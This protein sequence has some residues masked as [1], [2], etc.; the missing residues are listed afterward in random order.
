MEMT[1]VN[2]SEIK[3]VQY[4]TSHAKVPLIVLS[5]KVLRCIKES[6]ARCIMDTHVPSM[7][8]ECDGWIHRAV[9][10]SD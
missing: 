5:Q 1:L 3:S 2:F 8:M 6:H 4:F 10:N 9:F 7:C